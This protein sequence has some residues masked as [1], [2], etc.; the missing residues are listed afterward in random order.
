MLYAGQSGR[1]LGLKQAVVGFFGK[2][3]GS[4]F[5]RP[6][7]RGIRKQMLHVTNITLFWDFGRV[8]FRAKWNTKMALWSVSLS[9]FHFLK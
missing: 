3:G 9:V 7:G 8:T 6:P 1:E 5:W 2:S 4:D